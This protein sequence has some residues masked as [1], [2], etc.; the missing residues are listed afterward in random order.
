[1]DA[2]ST[3]SWSTPTIAIAGVVAVLAYA[4]VAL[5][6]ILVWNPE[7]AVPGLGADEIWRQVGQANQGPPNAFVVSVIAMGPL[8]AL[9]FLLLFTLTGAGAWPTAAGFLALLAMGAPG[10]FVASFGPGMGLADTFF[11][12]G[13]DAAPAGIVLGAVSVLAIVALAGIFVGAFVRDRR[14]RRLLAIS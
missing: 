13:G 8:F 4:A 11:I 7:A 5:V 10:Y 14:E 1:M 6:Q 3:R 12:D 9:V 2:V